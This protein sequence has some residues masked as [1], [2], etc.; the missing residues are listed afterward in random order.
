MGKHSLRHSTAGSDAPRPKK[1]LG[2]RDSQALGHT[3]NTGNQGRAANRIWD[4]G[5]DLARGPREKGEAPAGPMG[6]VIGLI[7]SF[8]LVAVMARSAERP[9]TED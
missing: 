7:I 6:R 1:R 4:S 5:L 2:P 3:G 9:S 8:G